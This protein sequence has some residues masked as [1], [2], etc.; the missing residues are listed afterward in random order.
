MVARHSIVEHI[1]SLMNVQWTKEQ[2][3]LD[4]TTVETVNNVRQNRDCKCKDFCQQILQ[5]KKTLRRAK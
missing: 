3:Q 4:V 5:N 2:S 1:S